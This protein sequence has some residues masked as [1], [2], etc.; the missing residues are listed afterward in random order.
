MRTFGTRQIFFTRLIPGVRVYATLVAGASNIPR[1][2]FMRA[3]VPAIVVWAAIMTA[4]G[5][6]VGIPAA[7]YLQSFE[8]LA[9]SGGV[10]VA[11]G[12]IGYRAATRATDPKHRIMSPA[13]HT[14]GGVARRDRYWIAGL[15]DFGFVAT[16]AAGIDRITRA[17]GLRLQ[18]PLAAPSGGSIDVIGI[19]TVLAATAL[20][21]FALS[22]RSKHGVTAGERLFDIS[23]I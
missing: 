10:L 3:S 21:Y 2:M 8:N 20:G 17:V 22:R 15:V 19:L 1:A 9:L 14:F 7:R 12:I 13:A 23:Y 18:S 6:F 16:I 5:Y 4:L 11:L